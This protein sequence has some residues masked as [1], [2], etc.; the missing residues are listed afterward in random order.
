M[1]GLFRLL[2]IPG[3]P[4]EQHRQ[5]VLVAQ[6]A[7]LPLQP[8]LALAGIFELFGHTFAVGA[9]A[10]LLRFESVNVLA[11]WLGLAACCGTV[12]SKRGGA[13]C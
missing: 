6:H 7:G 10:G 4:H 9:Q 1:I 13:G 2:R 8:G 11:Q 3:V 5:Q 12:G